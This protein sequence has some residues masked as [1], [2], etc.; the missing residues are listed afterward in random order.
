MCNKNVYKMLLKRSCNNNVFNKLLCCRPLS[1]CAI[2]N[3]RFVMNKLENKF[4]YHLP[5]ETVPLLF[6]NS[7]NLA[8][9]GS[10]SSTPCH[11]YCTQ[12]KQ[13]M[14]PKLMEFPEIF[15]PSII[16]SVRN[17]ILSN[18]IIMR[19]LDKDFNLQDF[20]TG[21]K[22]AVVVV[23]E[24]LS[25]GE[26]N[27]LEGLVSPEV[28]MEV[29]KSL[30]TFTMAQRQQLAVKEDDIYFSFPYEIGV[31]FPDDNEE[32]GKQ[33]R[34]V[35]ITMC[36][37]ILQGLREMKDQGDNIPLNIGVMPE[38]REKIFICNYRFI[39]DFTKGVDGDWTINALNHF[40][41]ADQME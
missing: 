2:Q 1:S 27:N 24:F 10:V 29:K 31:I 28:I 17:W 16:K 35:E 18:F 41:P 34:F 33:Q 20:I 32:G 9:C 4:L 38:F 37:H 25:R 36:Y 12:N 8:K 40:R 3:T 11:Y 21:S 19:Y 14:L 15:W 23:S 22:K 6:K 13:P 7:V 5:V 26:I 39:R 30:S